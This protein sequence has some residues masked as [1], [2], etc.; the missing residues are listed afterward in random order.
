MSNSNKKIK[1]IDINDKLSSFANAII[2]PEEDTTPKQI[3]DLGNDFEDNIAST[4]ISTRTEEPV[5]SGYQAI[6]NAK[7]QTLSNYDSSIHNAKTL[8][9]ARTFK[10]EREKKHPMNFYITA[11]N[12]HKLGKFMLEF[13]MGNTDAINFI[14]E[15]FFGSEQLT[16]EDFTLNNKD[17]N[18]KE[19]EAVSNYLEER[20]FKNARTPNA[21]NRIT[22]TAKDL[23]KLT[24]S[25]K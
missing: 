18:D 2:E 11:S 23:M 16:Y 10:T 9:E 6:H 25:K 12:A 19:K 8:G 20:F 3:E 24:K 7:K 17:L 21:P 14:L 15:Q 1:K 4:K 13:K 5:I 22:E